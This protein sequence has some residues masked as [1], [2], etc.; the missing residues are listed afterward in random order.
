MQSAGGSQVTGVADVAGV[1]EV[2]EPPR[3][4]LTQPAVDYQ[5]GSEAVELVTACGL[6][7]DSW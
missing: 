4:C 6:K 2:L 7:L 1:V 3:V 5:T